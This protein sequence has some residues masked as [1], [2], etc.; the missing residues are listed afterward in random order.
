MYPVQTISVI[1]TL[2][3]M[4]LLV[5]SL[6]N[7][8]RIVGVIVKMRKIA[9]RFACMALLGWLIICLRGTN[10]YKVSICSSHGFMC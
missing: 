7:A 10:F 9:T 4:F 6:R 3:F 5:I 8:Y 2:I 1:E